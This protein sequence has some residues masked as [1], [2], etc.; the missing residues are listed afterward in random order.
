MAEHAISVLMPFMTSASPPPH[1][2]LNGAALLANALN[3][4]DGVG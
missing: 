3:I 2:L 4:R 1:A